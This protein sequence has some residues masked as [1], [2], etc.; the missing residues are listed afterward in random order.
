M[1][2]DDAVPPAATPTAILE[3]R[4]GAD[5]GVLAE[6]L[7]PVL[8]RLKQLPCWPEAPGQGAQTVSQLRAV[9][10][11]AERDAASMRELAAAMQLSPPATSELVDRLVERGSVTR[12][13]HRHDRRQVLVTLT[14]AARTAWREVRDERLRRLTG[15]I[16]RLEPGERQ[17][18]VRGVMLLADEVASGGPAGCPSHGIQPHRR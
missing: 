4:L 17:G 12:E 14:P 6:L 18:F 2:K 13:P 8:P 16:A 9:A 3:D 11:L 1:R 10:W 7:L 5:P 15:V